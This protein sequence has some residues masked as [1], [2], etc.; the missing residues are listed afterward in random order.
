MT[1]QFLKLESASNYGTNLL[2]ADDCEN[3]LRNNYITA[4]H[5]VAFGGINT[6]FNYYKGLLNKERIKN[7]LSSIESYTLH[8]EFQSRQRNPTFAH[9]KRYQFQMDLV[10]VQNMAE[11]E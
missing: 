4:G 3:D 2:T 10:D 8:R 7:V 1:N 5:P 9:F 6:I 11:F